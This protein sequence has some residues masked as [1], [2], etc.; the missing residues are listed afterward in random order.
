[1][2]YGGEEYEYEWPDGNDNEGWG[3]DDQN[4]DGENPRIEIENAYYEAEGNMKEKPQEAIEQFE[5]CVL[6]EENLG[7]EI[8]HRFKAMENIVVLSARLHLFDKMKDN[9]QK[10]LKIIDKVARND[11]SDA[12]NN[13]LD[14]VAKHLTGQIDQQK[15]IYTMTLDVLK[16]QNQQLW[17]TICLRL[18]K[19]YLEQNN[20]KEL[21]DLLN[22]LKNS[23]RKQKVD[24]DG[25]Q[26]MSSRSSG[27]KAGVKIYE[28]YD[29]SKSNL[30][31]ETFALEIQMCNQINDKKRMK[32]VYPQTMNLNA[33]INDPRVMGIIK[34]C[35][36]KMYM[37]EKKWEKA[38]DELFECFKYY[39]ESGNIRAKNILVF[40]ILASMLCSSEINLADT[41][42]ARVYKDD[43]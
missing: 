12:V 1:M 22:D 43:P 31:L 6:M 33:V 28:E 23:C 24:N 36:G 19:I 30:L 4:D 5:N 17:C 42:E 9:H 10:I 32:R 15:Q 20:I 38:L 8:N 21:D 14:A 26:I 41:R 34:E 13:I 3:S 25:D 16:K 40:V 18:G 2:S 11:V 37:S 29:E 35:G 7:T 39:Q 27:P